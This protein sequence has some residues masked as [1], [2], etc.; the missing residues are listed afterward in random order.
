MAGAAVLLEQTIAMGKYQSRI[1]LTAVYPMPVSLD[2]QSLLIREI[3]LTP[4]VGYPNELTEVLATLEASSDVELA[5]YVSHQFNFNDFLQAFATAQE[6]TS[7][8]VMVT[9]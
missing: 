2:L 1:V 7:G 9:F 5:A 6:A 8:K 4:A 3:T